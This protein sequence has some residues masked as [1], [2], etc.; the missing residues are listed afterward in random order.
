[1]SGPKSA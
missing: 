1:M